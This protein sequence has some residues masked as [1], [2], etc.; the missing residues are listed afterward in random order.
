M[1]C[2]LE[3][4]GGRHL[5]S[6][7]RAGRNYMLLVTFFF[8]NVVEKHEIWLLNVKSHLYF[9]DVKKRRISAGD[10][11]PSDILVQNIKVS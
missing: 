7:E 2:H 4:G 11:A 1:T 10:I 6:G 5:D 9:R 3:G 8:A